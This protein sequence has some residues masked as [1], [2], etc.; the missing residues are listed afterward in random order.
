MRVAQK[1]V[2]LFRM[3]VRDKRSP[4]ENMYFQSEVYQL[5]YE[6]TYV[7]EKHNEYDASLPAKVT[8]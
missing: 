1:T 8:R 6:L 3:Y 7:W 2:P 5:K 4:V